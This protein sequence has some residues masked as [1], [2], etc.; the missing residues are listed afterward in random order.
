MTLL[1][2]HRD[3]RLTTWFSLYSISSLPPT[4]LHSKEPF[5]A[6]FIIISIQRNQETFPIAVLASSASQSVC[7]FSSIL[8]GIIYLGNTLI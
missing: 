3:F 6:S 1:L 2:D 4:P 5:L 8:R 7:H